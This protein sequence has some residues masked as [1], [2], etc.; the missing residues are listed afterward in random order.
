VPQGLG[1]PGANPLFF[2]VLT[3]I[4]LAVAAALGAGDQAPSVALHSNMVF[5]VEVGL[6]V[7]LATYFAIGAL[8]LAWHRTLFHKIGF[9]NAGAESPE[10]KETVAERD[11]KLEDFMAETTETLDNLEGRL[12]DLESASGSST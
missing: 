5:R 12:E 9:G 6:V 2:A 3:G 1:E 4:G 11:A 10:Q 7:A 8:W